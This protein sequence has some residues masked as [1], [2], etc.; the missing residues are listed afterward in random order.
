MSN[1]TYHQFRIP[2]DCHPLD[3]LFFCFGTSDDGLGKTAGPGILFCCMN[4]F[5]LGSDLKDLARDDFSAEF[6]VLYFCR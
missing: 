4:G 5:G 1:I 3:R 6:F 2:M